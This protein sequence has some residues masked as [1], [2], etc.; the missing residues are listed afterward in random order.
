MHNTYIPTS[1]TKEK[2]E[3]NSK[4]LWGIHNFSND[5]VAR[6]VEHHQRNAAGQ[7]IRFLICGCFWVWFFV[8]LSFSSWGRDCFSG[9]GS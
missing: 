1:Q 9:S 5:F 8:S 6:A 7:D 2:G 3:K 4:P